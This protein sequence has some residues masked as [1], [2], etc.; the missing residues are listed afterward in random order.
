MAPHMYVPMHVN[1]LRFPSSPLLQLVSFPV[2]YLILYVFIILLN[3]FVPCDE[4]I[5]M[6]S[7]ESRFSWQS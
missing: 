2:S 3:I 4:P 5:P 6:N 7:H 1:I